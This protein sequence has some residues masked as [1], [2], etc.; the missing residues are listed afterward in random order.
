MEHQLCKAAHLR[1]ALR[2]EAPRQQHEGCAP[3]HADSND[4]VEACDD[5]RGAVR[6][7]ASGRLLQR[8]D[9]VGAQ[10]QG[11]PD[12]APAGAGPPARWPVTASWGKPLPA[13]WCIHVSLTS[14]ILTL[15]LLLLMVASARVCP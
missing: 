11:P 5:A 7:V 12:G 13:R 14:S 3:R 6:A 1:A 4:A 8:G 15:H 9:A 2:R 10:A